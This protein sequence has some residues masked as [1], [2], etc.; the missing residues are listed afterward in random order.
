[1]FVPAE[2]GTGGWIRAVFVG[3][4]RPLYFARQ[5]LREC[6][7]GV[8]HRP[9]TVCGGFHPPYKCLTSARVRYNRRDPR[10]HRVQIEFHT[11]RSFGPSP[12]KNTRR[13]QRVRQRYQRVTA[14]ATKCAREVVIGGGVLKGRTP[15]NLS[16]HHEALHAIY[17]IRGDT[18]TPLCLS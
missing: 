4:V 5:R 8:T 12:S 11:W 13:T 3:G 9:H 6:R 14:G 15:R 16:N 1:M 2:T 10:R 7:V 17:R 18:S